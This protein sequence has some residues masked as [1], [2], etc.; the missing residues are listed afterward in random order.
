M[1]FTFKYLLKYRVLD[2][3]SIS[4]SLLSYVFNRVPAHRAKKHHT[5]FFILG[6]FLGKVCL[7]PS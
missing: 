5:V 7:S 4:F 2:L 1:I 3:S 6:V